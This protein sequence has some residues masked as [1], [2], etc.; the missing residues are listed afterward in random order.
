[1]GNGYFLLGS[2]FGVELVLST[3]HDTECGNPTL[4]LF[5]GSGFFSV[6][7]FSNGVEVELDT[8]PEG[9]SSWGQINF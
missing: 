9:R 2:V 8:E 6:K 5:L 4:F 3:S 1:M 7:R